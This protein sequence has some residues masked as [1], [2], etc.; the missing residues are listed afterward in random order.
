MVKVQFGLRGTGNVIGPNTAT[1]RAIA[2]YNLAT[3][4]VIQNSPVI[5][6]SGG[7]VNIPAGQ[8]YFIGAINIF[9]SPILTG[10]PEITTTPPLGDN[11]H[12]IADTAFVI[13]NSGGSGDVHGPAGATDAAVALFNGATGKIIRNSTV[14]INTLGD[15]NIPAG[16]KYYIGSVPLG[17]GDVAGPGS[18][19]NNAIV[20]F[21][22]GTGKIIKNSLVTINS[23]GSVNL[24][25]GQGY[26]VGSVNILYNTTLTGTSYISATPPIR[27]A[28]L[29]IANTDYV[30]T[31]GVAGN[32]IFTALGDIP[33]GLGSA[34]AGVLH[35][36]LAGQFLM[37]Y[38]GTP[39]WVTVTPGT[40]DVHG[41]AVSTDHAIAR[42]D[43]VL[44]KTLLDSPAATVSDTGQI[45]ALSFTTTLSHTSISISGNA[46]A[47][48][49]LLPPY[50]AATD[51]R[52][53]TASSGNLQIYLGIG[54]ASF[55]GSRITGVQTVSPITGDSN[56][57]ASID[58]VNTF[59]IANNKIFD[60]LG[61]LVVG[62][63]N[64][65]AGRLPIGTAGQFLMVYG[66]APA[67]LTPTGFGNVSG[68]GV[69]TDRAIAR[70]NSTTG[71]LLLNSPVTIADDGTVD[72]V[73]TVSPTGGT[74]YNAASKDYVDTF[75]VAYNKI[76]T[77]VGQIPVGTGSG[78]ASVLSVGTNG[79]F[80]MMYG[81]GP[82]WQTPTL[83]NVTGPASVTSDG[84]IAIF[85]G[86]TGKIIKDSTLNIS[87]F[88]RIKRGKDYYI[89][90][91]GDYI[92]HNMGADV[93]FVV[94]VKGVIPY[95]VVVDNH[96]VNAVLLHGFSLAGIN[97]AVTV[98][99][100]AVAL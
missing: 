91:A 98:D 5:I 47:S 7:S 99:W 14:I 87:D 20:V 38:G 54:Y 41:P 31:F 85:N 77:A 71:K 55:N 15:V 89:A 49:D 21:D 17:T 4:K 86:T 68:P 66:G 83:G 16:R 90:A 61:D 67:W 46:I 6:N 27:D 58:Y 9:D 23:L 63:G 60:T 8:G 57:V 81:G 64:D 72:G 94:T 48:A 39:S 79:Q 69:S 28:S 42:Y 70:Y 40:G 19:T 32:K 65:T 53:Y 75:A 100:V 78:T 33:V 50:T 92:Y 62:T 59:G 73:K 80:L 51:L 93:A 3:G 25:S 24:P 56:D 96:T 88:P 44:G 52:L 13:A 37:V 74:A 95:V 11:T 84:N 82:S 35:L 18:A 45:T 26:Y 30:D 10:T 2:I 1:D 22:G 12:K 97:S 43:G 29:K 34:S 36:G 76:F